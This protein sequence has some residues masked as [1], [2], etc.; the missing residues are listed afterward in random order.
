MTQDRASY[1]HVVMPQAQVNVSR[2]VNHL[3][4][5]AHQ[6]YT[7]ISTL[8]TLPSGQVSANGRDLPAL[9]CARSLA[10]L[11]PWGEMRRLG[12]GCGH[13]LPFPTMRNGR[14][15]QST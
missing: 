8:S 14:R 10:P 5:V 3:M 15:W 6:R 2:I 9:T 4:L 1:L 11:L 7:T 12:Y 13:P